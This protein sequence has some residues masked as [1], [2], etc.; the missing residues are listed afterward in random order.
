M[1]ETFIIW[2]KAVDAEFR[3]AYE[4]EVGEAIQPDPIE[5]DT[6]Y[7]IGSSRVTTDQLE[8][9]G[10]QFDGVMSSQTWPESF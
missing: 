1:D 7:L 9:L 4:S 8:A 2:P 6:H 10:A 3:A 5:N